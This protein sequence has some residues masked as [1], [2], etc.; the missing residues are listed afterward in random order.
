MMDLV[1]VEGQ[2]GLARD[3][4]T[5]AVL[6]INSTEINRIKELRKNQRDLK[7]VEREEINQLKSDVAE[8]KM[9]LSKIV[10]KL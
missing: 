9:I 8:I 4:K 3:K 10:E 7:K 5:G 1:K 6:N 2:P